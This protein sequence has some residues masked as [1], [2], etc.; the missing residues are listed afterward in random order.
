MN[1]SSNSHSIDAILVAGIGNIF[2]G[3]DG[4][5]SE[6]ARQLLLLDWPDDVRVVDYGIR[7]IDLAYALL[8]GHEAVILIDAIPGDEAPGTLRVIE[9][10]LEGLELESN[11]SALLDA[12]SLHPLRVL[13]MVKA[14]G[15]DLKRVMI[16]GCQP[17][18]LG[19][20]EGRM[21]LS[22]PV[23]AAVSE[24]VKLVKRLSET[25][26]T[27]RLEASSRIHKGSNKLCTNFRSQ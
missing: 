7:G 12:H 27:Q 26:L 1:L 11:P 9:P 19:G 23:G 10:E 4:F 15:G 16:V 25:L 17:A 8:D 24:A 21:G 3:D 18:D 14:M 6:V 2:L 13:Q 22:A 5:G 20:E